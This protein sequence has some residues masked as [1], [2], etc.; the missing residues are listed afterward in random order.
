VP[1]ADVERVESAA[2]ML[3]AVRAH[4]D[5][6]DAL[7]SAAA[8]S[9]FT[10]EPRAE[11]I[12][13]GEA[14]TLALEPTPKLIDAVREAHPDLTVV[15]FKLESGA[16]DAG[17]VAEA[18]DQIDRA[19]CAFVV[20]NDAS[21]IGDEDTRALIVRGGSVGEFEGSKDGLGLRVADELAAEL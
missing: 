14:L 16:D 2:E 20:A 8:I 19:G 12:E 9:D 21:V 11:K 1:Y 17:L 13:S 10:V 3:E 4:A 7:V 18:R 5:G 15:G 6:A